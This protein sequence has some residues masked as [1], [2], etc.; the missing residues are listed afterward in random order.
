LKNN[1]AFVCLIVSKIEDEVVS[2]LGLRQ[3]W[4]AI[5]GE[6]KQEV[7]LQPVSCGEGTFDQ[8]SHEKTT[9]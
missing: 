8:D 7:H 4:R 6:T 9:L 2:V 3:T 5:G 1:S